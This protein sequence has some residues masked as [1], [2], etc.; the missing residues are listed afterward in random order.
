M[1]V[2]F[3]YFIADDT[4]RYIVDAVSLVA[5]HGRAA[6]A[7]LPLRSRQRPVAPPRRLAAAPLS[8]HDISYDGATM[9]YRRPPTLLPDGGLA[10]YLDRARPLIGELAADSARAA[11][12]PDTNADF[13]H[14]R[15]FHY[16]DEILDATA[17]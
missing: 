8:L 5:D 11:R 7:V 16:P 2:N 13:E 14:L 3:N 6:A 12:P 4:F 1:R 17:G 15:W 10:G 9:S